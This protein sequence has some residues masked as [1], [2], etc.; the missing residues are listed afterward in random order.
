MGNRIKVDGVVCNARM[1]K[2]NTSQLAIKMKDV[3][4]VYRK[5]Y[6]RDMVAE[7]R[8]QFYLDNVYNMY[9]L[10]KAIQADME[11]NGR[12]GSAIIK[13]RGCSEG[14]NN[15]MQACGITGQADNTKGSSDDSGQ[16]VDSGGNEMLQ[17]YGYAINTLN[18]VVKV[19]ERV[20]ALKAQ[21]KALQAF[22]SVIIAPVLNA[23]LC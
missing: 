17:M 21:F 6:Q 3:F 19:W 15:A 13:T 5:A 10:V 12:I 7:K 20:A 23:S 1:D 22:M 9:A 18:D 8:R 16:D 14:G 4:L 2:I 11:D